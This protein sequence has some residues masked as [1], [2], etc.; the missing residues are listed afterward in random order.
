MKTVGL[1]SDT[2]FNEI[3]R[4]RMCKFDCK[5]WLYSDNGS[6]KPGQKNVVFF[7]GRIDLFWKMKSRK[8]WVAVE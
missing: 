6:W 2:D 4:Q 8:Q 3:K 7:S 1:L 5:V